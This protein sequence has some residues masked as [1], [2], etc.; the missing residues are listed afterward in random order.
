MNSPE[1]KLERRESTTSQAVTQSIEPADG[2]DDGQSN[3][4]EPSSDSI[5]NNAMMNGMQSQMSFGFPNQG[6][7]NN[8]MG[9]NG[10]PNMMTNGN[11]NGKIPMRFSL[12]DILQSTKLTRVRLQPH[13]RHAK[14]HVRKFRW[15]H[16]HER[17]VGH[18]HVEL[19]WRLWQWVEWHGRGLWELQRV[20]PDG[21][22]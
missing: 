2:P 18:E 1:I 15:K 10:M 17:H 7:F 5:N 16:G 19:W 20:Q 14:R 4:N 8:G 22:L 11:W 12:R 21:W 13:E 9:W 6:S 3:A